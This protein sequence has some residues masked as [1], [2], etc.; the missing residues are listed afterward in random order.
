MH[1]PSASL[2]TCTRS[3][4][5]RYRCSHLSWRELPPLAEVLSRGEA[6]SLCLSPRADY[7]DNIHDTFFFQQS[8]IGTILERYRAMMKCAIWCC[9]P[10]GCA[11]KCTEDNDKNVSC[12]AQ[13]SHCFRPAGANCSHIVLSLYELPVSVAASLW[14]DHPP[15]F[16][17]NL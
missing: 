17:V 2:L 1:R 11:A 10:S 6:E 14:I 13:L 16:G 9:A 12:I 8:S 4:P 3:T 7:G 5:C 15:F